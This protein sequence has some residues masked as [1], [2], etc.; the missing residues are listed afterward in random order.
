MTSKAPQPQPEGITR[1]AVAPAAPPPRPGDKVE[2][3]RGLLEVSL[4]VRD[5]QTKVLEERAQRIASLEALVH[6]LAKDRF[7]LDWLESLGIETIYFVGGEAVIVGQG[8]PLRETLAGFINRG[9]QQQ[10]QEQNP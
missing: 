9:K 3:L 1:P 5:Q 2:Q 4:D 7:L 10:Q 8:R 6:K